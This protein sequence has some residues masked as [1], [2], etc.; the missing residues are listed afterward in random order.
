MINQAQSTTVINTSAAQ[1]WAKLEQGTLEACMLRAEGRTDEAMRL[2]Q[3]QMP[4]WI[5]AWSS[6]CELPRATA[7]EK[8][9]RMFAETE[10]FVGRGVA[11]RRLITAELIDLRDKRL[12]EK[13]RIPVPDHHA[14]V[15][16]RQAVK[17]DDIEAMLDGL[18]E[19]ER[20]TRREALWPLRSRATLAAAAF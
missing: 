8:L 2:L 11:Q 14:P 5:K 20:E 13:C 12:G 19:A 18:A 1:L 15:G 9:R 10:D 16:L 17:L 4:A 3:G 6:Q 7:Q